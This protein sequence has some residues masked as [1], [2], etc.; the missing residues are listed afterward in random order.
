MSE[1]SRFDEIVKQRYRTGQMLR[2]YRLQLVCRCILGGQPS[3]AGHPGCDRTGPDRVFRIAVRRYFR[4]SGDGTLPVA[5]GLLLG[6]GLVFLA[7]A[8]K[9]LK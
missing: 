6:R 8:T 1:R 3:V 7:D 5:V 2:R 4:R 9:G